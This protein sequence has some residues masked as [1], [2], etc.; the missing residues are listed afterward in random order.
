MRTV[1]KNRTFS[2]DPDL[3]RAIERTR[4]KRSASERAN[5]LLRRALEAERAA[6]L[7]REAAEF[8]AQ[9]PGDDDERQGF[10][11]AGLR[12]WVRE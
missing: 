11:A 7:D 1:R 4:G 10:Q 12:S 6:A 8:F 5:E 9:E 2:L 3:I